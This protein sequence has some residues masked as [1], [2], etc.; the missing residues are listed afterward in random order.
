MKKFLALAAIAAMLAGCSTASSGDAA[1]DSKKLEK[2]QVCVNGKVWQDHEPGN[3][4][5]AK[6]VIENGQQK[7]CERN[8]SRLGG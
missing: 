4:E 5:F 6:P 1:K 2:G 8:S 3:V 7:S